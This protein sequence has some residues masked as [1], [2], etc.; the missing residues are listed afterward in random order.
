MDYISIIFAAIG[1]G[2]GGLLGSY[3]SR[4]ISP[5]NEAGRRVAML[6]PVLILSSIF[7]EI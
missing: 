7:S 3:F 1:G 6:I 5:K 4:R 2:L